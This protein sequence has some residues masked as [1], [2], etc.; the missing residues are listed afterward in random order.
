MLHGNRNKDRFSA[1]RDSTSADL[2]VF[3]LLILLSFTLGFDI[4]TADLKGAYMQSEPMKW[5]LIVCSPNQIVAL[6]I[7]WKLLR[8]PN[9]IAEAGGQW[10]YAVENWLT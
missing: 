2:S 7:F 10:L 6:N 4:A 1:I 3:R 8:L 5:K 9:G